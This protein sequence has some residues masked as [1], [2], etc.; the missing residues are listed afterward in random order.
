MSAAGTWFE[1][2]RSRQILLL[3]GPIIAGMGSQTL[4]NLVDTGMVGR[5]GPAPQAAAGLGSFTFWVLANLIIALGAGVQA[6]VARRDGEEDREGA[7]SGLDTG[8][9]LAVLI[10]LPLGYTL[11][12]AAPWLFSLLTDDAA[13]SAGGSRYLAIRLMGL[14]A[15]AANYC[16]RGFYNGVGRSMVY[17]STL[18]VIHGANVFLNWVF[19][20]GNFGAR[21]MGVEGAALAS[22]LAAVIGTCVY[23]ILTLTQ[24]DVRTVYKPF[25]FRNIRPDRVASLV[26][27]SVPEAVRGVLVMLG[28]LLFLD[29]HETIGTRAAA[30]GTILVNIASAGFLP[31][32]G[33]GMAGATLVGRHLGRGEPDEARRLMWLAV[34]LGATGIAVPAILLAVFAEPVL[35]IFTPDA[36][37]IE[38]AVPALRLFAVAAIFDVLPIVLVFS[39]LGAGATRWVAG[40]QIFQQYILLLPLAA[41]LGLVLEMGIFGLWVGMFLSRLGLAAFAIVKVQGDGWTRIEV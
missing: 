39:L 29:L 5:L 31:A 24:A 37:T 7:G 17:M 41:L 27:L 11:A 6:I 38:A 12:E 32:M 20:Y 36:P 28:F 35:A 8:L 1:R 34:R 4:M 14:G 22:V 10:G 18:I 15:V 23:S 2:E 25:R 3:A 19:I 9:L 16:F 21:A 13:V 26:R 40:V 30:A 33:M